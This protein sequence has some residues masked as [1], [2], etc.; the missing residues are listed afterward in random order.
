MNKDPV[1]GMNVDPKTAAGSSDYQGERF[2]FCSKACK[3]K[4]DKNPSQYT[5]KMQPESTRR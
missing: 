2:S 4:F 5:Q 1:C 3:E